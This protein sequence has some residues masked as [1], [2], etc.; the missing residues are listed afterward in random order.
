M[1]D[2]TPEPT[3][4]PTPGPPPRDSPVRSATRGVL[5]GLFWA[6]AAAGIWAGIFAL[7][8]PVH[9][10]L[11]ALN[12]ERQ[13]W[14]ISYLGWL[15]LAATWALIVW[16]VLSPARARQSACM[17]HD[18]RYRNLVSGAPTVSWVTLTDPQPT[19][20]IGARY[21]RFWCSRCRRTWLFPK[22]K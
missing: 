3:P 11:D 18:P 19:G 5:T 17:H 16:H 7:S 8:I 1:S 21:V 10:A 20:R 13:P 9:W 14:P 6:G 4:E 2:P 22:V 15:M 12:L